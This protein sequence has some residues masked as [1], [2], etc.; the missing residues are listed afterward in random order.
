MTKHT[1]I[2]IPEFLIKRIEVKLKQGYIGKA[3]FIDQ[4]IRNELNF[5]DQLYGPEEA[6]NNDL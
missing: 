6:G 3:D 1:L 4:C 5:L 2:S